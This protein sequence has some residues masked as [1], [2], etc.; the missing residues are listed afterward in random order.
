VIFLDTGFL[1]AYVSADDRDHARVAEV[2]DVASG[3]PPSFSRRTT[4]SPRRSPS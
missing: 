2:L 4:S 1:F 3:S